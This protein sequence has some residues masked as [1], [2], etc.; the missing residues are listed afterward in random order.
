MPQ[1]DSFRAGEKTLC[2]AYLSGGP[3][4]IRVVSSKGQALGRVPLD[5][6]VSVDNLE[7]TAS[8]DLL[9]NERGYIQFS[10]WRREIQTGTIRFGKKL[11]EDQESRI[12]A[13]SRPRPVV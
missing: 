11:G 12:L 8:E 1:I 10:C 2:I 7:V 6:I 5:G 3:C 13:S 9:F 4:E